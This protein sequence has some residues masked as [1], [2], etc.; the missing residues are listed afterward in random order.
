MRAWLKLTLVWL[1]H[2]QLSCFLLLVLHIRVIAFKVSL[3]A[4]MGRLEDLS[5]I[6]HKSSAVNCIRKL[7]TSCT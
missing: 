5:S 7:L 1:V 2:L 6:L 3:A 4:I